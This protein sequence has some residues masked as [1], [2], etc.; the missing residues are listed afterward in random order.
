MAQ[1]ILFFR[2]S[3]TDYSDPNVVASASQGNVFAKFAIDRTNLSGWATTGSV[4][5]DNTTFEVNIVNMKSVTDIILL[6]HNFKS[7]KVEWWDGSIYQP[8]VPAIQPT[9]NTMR[10]TR[11]SV[12]RV[13]TTKLRLTVYGTMT[14][15]DQKFLGTFIATE[16]IGQ[17]E[18]FPVIQAPKLGRNKQSS[19]MIS[20]KKSIRENVGNFACQLTVNN[21]NKDADLTIVETLYRL[22]DGFLVWLSGGDE[23]QFSSLREAYRKQDI[24]LMKTSN[25]LSPEWYKG[26]YSTGMKIKIDLEEVVD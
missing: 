11:Y 4:D 14:A 1:P 13:N 2:K 23:D 21:W 9:T 15:N 20:G 22:N 19:T 18:G 26:I 12:T 6:R 25:D 16:L 3:K 17:L 7:F 5:A 24:Y 8:F 10:D